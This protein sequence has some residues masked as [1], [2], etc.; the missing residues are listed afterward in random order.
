MG[1]GVQ[2]FL[3]REKMKNPDCETCVHFELCDILEIKALEDK[4]RPRSCRFFEL[5]IPDAETTK[6]RGQE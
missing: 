4:P 3:W 6:P 1:A 2:M 5:S